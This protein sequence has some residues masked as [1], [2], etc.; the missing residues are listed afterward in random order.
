MSNNLETLKKQEIDFWREYAPY[1][2]YLHLSAPYKKLYEVTKEMIM[3]KKGEIWWDSGCG[4]GHMARSI[5]WKSNEEVKEIVATDLFETL[6]PIA[7]RSIPISF[8]DDC[9]LSKK[10][11][12]ADNYFDGMVAGMVR[13]YI[14]DYQGISGKEG[15]ALATKEMYRVIKHG[16]QI[17]WSTP[18][19]EVD[20]TKVLIA[21]V[22]SILNPIHSITNK[23]FMPYIGF[24]VLKYAKEIERK[25][26]Q[27]L[28]HFYGIDEHIEVMK[29]VGFKNITYKLAF[30]GQDVVFSAFK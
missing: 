15:F 5:W 18:I 29:E 26:K 17:V 2:K 30:A 13:T 28:Y 4:P 10:L 16:G 8:R 9:D 25:G 12:F 27:G 24:K 20:F 3:P 7:T 6:C 23:Q 1:Y 11:P 21:S 22:P 19:K 14:I